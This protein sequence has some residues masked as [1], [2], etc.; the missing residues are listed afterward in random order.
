M[1]PI[2]ITIRGAGIFGLSIAW[3]CAR[4]GAHVRVIDPHGPGAGSSGGLVGA[5]APHVPENWNV[6]KAFQLDSLLMAEGFWAGVTAAGGVDPGYV[7]SGRLQPVA[8]EALPL[9]RARGEG[10]AELWQGRAVWE[11][12]PAAEAGPWAPLSPSGFLIRDTLTAL[13]H[14]RRA[15]A[16]LTA[17]LAVRGIEI[18]P[19]GEDTGRVLHATG[20]AGLA[21]LSAALGRNVGGAVK[22]QAALLRH[23]APG[24]PQLFVDGLHIVPHLDGTVAIGSTSERDF[25]DPTGTDAQLDTLVERARAALPILHGAPVVARWAGLRPRSRSRA[26]MLGAHPLHP[27]Q[28]I[29]NGGFKIGF[30]MAP[31]VAEVM[32]DLLLEGRDEIPEAFRVEASM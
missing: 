30:G 15:C 16:A 18:T 24:A 19:E 17:A 12:I 31:K 3:A 9:A 32:A 10:A 13:L 14:P 22:G 25:D 20:A 1:P 23:A 2:D 28:F 4:R 21:E 5:L 7:R 11:V 29:A 8:E 6:K 26:P 27:G